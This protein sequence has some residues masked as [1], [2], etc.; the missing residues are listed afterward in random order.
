MMAESMGAD[1]DAPLALAI[2]VRRSEKIP[3]GASSMSPGSKAYKE[4]PK[5]E[6]SQKMWIQ[7]NEL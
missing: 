4:L 3:S 2:T 5:A 7:N 6:M 1:S